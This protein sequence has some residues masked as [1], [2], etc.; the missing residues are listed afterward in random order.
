[1]ALLAATGL[2]LLG[3]RLAV[4]P[5]R[6]LSAYA[7]EHAAVAPLP[8]LPGVLLANGSRAVG[9]LW[10]DWSGTAPGFWI[11]AL[12]LLT[13]LLALAPL[14]HQG[15]RRSA[16]RAAGLL[17]LAWA[18]AHGP[19]LAL[20]QPVI[21]ARTFLPLGAVLA[22]A[23]LFS[24]AAVRR[25]VEER[26]LPAGAQRALAVPLLALVGSLAV[27]AYSYAHAYGQQ[28]RLEAVLLGQLGVGLDQIPVERWGQLRQI[29]CIGRLPRSPALAQAIRRFPAF[30][31]M[32]SPLVGNGAFGPMQLRSLT[33]IDLAYAP[34]TPERTARA[35]AG[36]LPTLFESR[37]YHAMQDGPVLVVVTR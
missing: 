37:R 2:A 1:L 5:I 33:A 15:S 25:L 32:V 26:A 12:L 9:T 13:L 19:Q 28:R 20:A 21:D 35:L 23:V 4:L 24:E 6:R 29:D 17:L 27:T 3:Y 22:S 16:L 30:E 7:R 8:G 34:P 11:A 36:Q 18:V 31:G 14:R 10:R